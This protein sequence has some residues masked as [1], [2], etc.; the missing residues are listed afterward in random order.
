M[1]SNEKTIN[2]IIKSNEKTAPGSSVESM[3]IRMQ[4]FYGDLTQKRM[5]LKQKNE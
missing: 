2:T 3:L 5:K 4:D 1:K